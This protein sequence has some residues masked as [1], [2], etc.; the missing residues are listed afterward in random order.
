[1]SFFG[2]QFYTLFLHIHD[3]NDDFLSIATEAVCLKV[4]FSNS[5][6]LAQVPLFFCSG[7]F[8][9]LMVFDFP[10]KVNKFAIKK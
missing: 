4:C 1:M 7:D 6:T 5:F 8:G 3:Q 2:Y 10:I 9:I